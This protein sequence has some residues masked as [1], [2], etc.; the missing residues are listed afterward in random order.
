MANSRKCSLEDCDKP[1]EARG[2]CQNHYRQRFRKSR[3][4]TPHKPKRIEWLESQINHPDT[5]N[6]LRWPF[7]ID[8]RTGYGIADYK[9]KSMPASR[10]MCI[11]CHGEPPSK[12]LQAAHSCGNGHNACVNPHHLRWATRAENQKDKVTHG[13]SN[14]V[15][16]DD[17]V[18][19]I[20]NLR[21]VLTS[22]TIAAMYGVNRATITKI[23]LQQKRKNV[24]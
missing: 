5:V 10:L 12:D 13:T 11:L 15:L 21:G 3:S 24:L 19:K 7:R 23:Q 6:C 22:N 9:S 20:R 14:A 1:H 8:H 4:R 18:R 2:F 17:D 16:S